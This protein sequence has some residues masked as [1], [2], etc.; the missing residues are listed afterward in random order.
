M[1]SSYKVHPSICERIDPIN[2]NGRTSRST[3]K[4]EEA[5]MPAISP[6]LF[7]LAMSCK[8]VQLTR[9]LNSN[10]WKVVF[11]QILWKRKDLCKLKI[12]RCS[13]VCGALLQVPQ[14]LGHVLAELP[15]LG[16]AQSAL[17]TWKF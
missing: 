8:F 16:D 5:D 1:F 14:A 4:V 9:L 3:W 7:S 17:Q 11:S 6:A 12:F 15:P 2:N 13:L 10:A